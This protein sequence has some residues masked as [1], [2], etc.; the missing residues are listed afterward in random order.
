MLSQ[1]SFDS[2]ACI[3]RLP[4]FPPSPQRN[5]RLPYD[6]ASR[7]SSHRAI[8]FFDSP[9]RHLCLSLPSCHLLS[10]LLFCFS[11]LRTPCRHRCRDRALRISIGL[12]RT[13][14]DRVK[15]LGLGTKWLAAR[16]L[17][18]G[19]PKRLCG[20]HHQASGDEQVP[21]TFRDSP[22]LPHK[23]IAQPRHLASLL[24]RASSLVPVMVFQ[25]PD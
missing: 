14:P 8:R 4:T 9:P 12:G 10:P 7:T 17:P 6:C 13:R 25:P 16:F 20:R 1:A 15:C 3:P 24:L 5:Y 19:Q 22:I 18:L 11:T 23:P 2:V 21:A